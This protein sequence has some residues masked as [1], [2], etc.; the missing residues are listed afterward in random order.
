MTGPARTPLVP[1]RVVLCGAAASALSLALAACGGTAATPTRS[2][3]APTG[4]SAP[5]PAATTIGA[6]ATAVA[7]T[8][9][10]TTANGVLAQ[11]RSR[12]VI[13][14][15]NTQ[16]NP[17]WNFLDEKNQVA[18]YDV[19]VANEIAK[20][21]GVPKVEYIGSDFQSFIP[22]VQSGRYDIVI[23]GQTVTEERKKQVDFSDPY[24]VNGV[25]IFV[26]S[27]NS[28]I[29]TQADLAG[30][31]IAVTAGTT[32]EQ[33]AR[34]KIPNADIKTYENATLALTDVALGRADASLVSRFVGA[35]L[36]DKN[37]LKVKPTEGFLNTE[38]N[39]MSFKKGE[40]TLMME[41]NKALAAM[42]ADG[43]LTTISKKWLGGLDMA[44]ELK[45]LPK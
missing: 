45:A 11:V 14:V 21:L 38:V 43:T 23:A 18:G 35:Y 30:K 7:T 36:A 3:A 41:V 12:G 6:S 33:F 16:A 31:R 24:Q 44:A 37:N 19:D 32:N 15:A 40:T 9:A 34:D 29:K 39:A 20:R 25:S 2:A 17:P 28:T 10:S 42:I 13:R 26:G 5:V 4:T 27:S 8:G 22:G 1:R